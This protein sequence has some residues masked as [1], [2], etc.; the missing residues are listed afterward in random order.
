MY[1]FLL[2]IAAIVSVVAFLGPAGAEAQSGNGRV[3]VMHASPDTPPAD[4]FVDGQKAIS[5]LAFPNATG[6][7]SLA[8][9]PHEVKVFVSPSD[10]SGAPALQATLTIEAN[11][12]VTV[13]A[14]GR[15]SDGSLELLP[16]QDTNTLPQAGKAHVRFIHASPD[17]PAVDVVVRGSGAALFTNVE[18]KEV[19]SYVAVDAGTYDLDVRVASTDTVALPLDGVRLEAGTV[20]TVV[21]VGLVGD[22]TLSAVPLVDATAPAPPHTGT[23][24]APSAEQA[25]NP[26]L[27]FVAAGAALLLAAAALLRLAR[28]TPA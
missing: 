17:A 10:G 25:A 3:R 15:V 4:V 7:V 28:R 2:V 26:A 19:G 13:L 27:P 12:D 14:V 6:Y 9:G 20:Y 5:G 8:A 21:A 23:G 11:R 16:V 1:R 18:F 22:G 24:L